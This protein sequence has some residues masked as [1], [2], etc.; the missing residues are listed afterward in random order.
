M[1]M[2]RISIAACKPKRKPS[3]ISKLLL[4]AFNGY[5]N[6]SL[7]GKATTAIKAIIIMMT[8]TTIILIRRRM[9]MMNHRLHLPQ[10]GLLQSSPMLS[11][12]SKLS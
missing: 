3:R 8:T 11:K 5:L 9:E 6:K 2:I 12:A 4:I 1:A 7:R 10:M